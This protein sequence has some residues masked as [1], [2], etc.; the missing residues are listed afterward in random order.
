MSLSMKQVRACQLIAKGYKDKDVWPSVGISEVTYYRWKKL[1]GFSDCLSFFQKEE[2]EKAA[3]I[4]AAV[5]EAD[6][7]EQSREDEAEIREQIKRLALNTC[8]LA[9]TLIQNVLDADG[10]G[11]SP[12][13]IPG[14]VKAATDAVACLRDGNERPTGLEGLLDELG[15]IEKEISAKGLEFHQ[16]QANQTA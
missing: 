5:G 11:L 7:L 9:N 6:E 4:T 14:L 10:E 12:R 8:K 2:L 1:R 16:T 15:K 13:A 3:A